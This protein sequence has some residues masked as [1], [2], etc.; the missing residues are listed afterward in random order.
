M[1]DTLKEDAEDAITAYFKNPSPTSIV[2]FVAD[3]LNGNRKL[4]KLLKSHPAAVEFKKLD[5]SE[6]HVWTEE[7]FRKADVAIEPRASRRLIDLVG[8]D[9][10]R[11][12]TESAKLCTASLPGKKIDA[13]LVEMHV[14]ST[15]DLGNFSFAEHL[16]EG[17]KTEAVTELRKLL[18][19]GEE[20]LAL[21][22]TLG[23]KYREAMKKTNPSSNS[24]H[25]D[26]LVRSIQRIAETD[27]RIKTSVGGG[28]PKGARMQI[29]ML[30]CELS[31]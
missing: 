12:E 26:R 2:V 5:Q 30:V 8:S 14:R 27:L 23:W 17:R 15:R 25:A 11:I 10:R 29:E 28:G 9:V 3:E 21:L 6:L 18:N 4:G 22:G 13:G 31:D 16:I 19:D 24:K 7:I 20:P 1:K